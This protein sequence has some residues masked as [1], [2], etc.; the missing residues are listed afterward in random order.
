[1]NPHSTILMKHSQLSLTN[2]KSKP[3]CTTYLL[4][5][6]NK[7]AVR[8]LMFTIS[9]FFLG[10]HHSLAPPELIEYFKIKMDLLLHFHELIAQ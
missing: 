1:M 5:K 3:K 10:H 4:D 8:Y 6:Q 7:I 9:S 2:S